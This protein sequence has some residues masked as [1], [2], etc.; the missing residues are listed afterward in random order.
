M[1]V[2]ASLLA[3][4]FL[5]CA[6]AQAETTTYW[7]NGAIG[8]TFNT[9][10]NWLVSDGSGGYVTA[11]IYPPL[12][13]DTIIKRA[14][15]N[16][17]T[18]PLPAW[19]T[20]ASST[21]L[22]T[23]FTIGEWANESA[24]NTAW[25]V[26]FKNAN[27]TFNTLTQN[28]TSETRLRRQAS[29]SSLDF[30]AGTVNVSLGKVS[31]GF[32][33]ADQFAGTVTITNSIN[34][35]GGEFASS[36]NTFN[37]SAATVNLNGG[38]MTINQ[39][40]G[41]GTA[42]YLVATPTVATL[43][44]VNIQAANVLAFGVSGRYIQTASIDTLNATN[45]NATNYAVIDAYATNG[46]TINEIN[47][48]D[49]RFYFNAGNGVTI[50]ENFTVLGVGNT[51][52]SSRGGTTTVKK[53]LDIAG[54]SQ[55][56]IILNGNADATHDSYLSVGGITGGGGTS[57]RRISTQYSTNPSSVDLGNAYITITGV[58]GT[59]GN[60]SVFTGRLHDM[61][62]SHT[63]DQMMDV[64]KIYVTMNSTDPTAKQ[65]IAG[66]TYYRGDTTIIN[67]NLYI[68][69]DKTGNTT[70]GI[71]KVI[72][73]GGG[74]GA[75]G[76]GDA[77]GN[78]AA[79]GTVYATDL[80]WSGGSILVDI[81]GAT[82][83]KLIFSGTVGMSGAAESYAIN[84]NIINFSEGQTYE[85]IQWTDAGSAADFDESK[86]AAEFEQAGYSAL[87]EKTATGLNV[88]LSAIPEPAQF[89]ALFGLAALLIA[90]RRKSRKN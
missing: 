24:S 25:D 69:A 88:T 12:T 1:R 8:G 45:P 43:G 22:Q 29:A 6:A 33:G 79:V 54:T 90:I 66:Q 14:D 71:A 37:A 78:V 57:S 67:G 15:Q 48:T 7:W 40:F 23:T 38:N 26:Y 47:A 42:G 65:Y 82:A 70:W 77:A 63:I 89:A 60:T 13:A 21:P 55:C 10:S 35:T 3:A 74:F 20:N 83:D 85:I 87:F 2:K 75:C 44:T 31:L 4:A 59:T 62:Q 34:V 18:V 30:T 39:S 56:S 73:Q 36:A 16:S 86:L 9:A 17:S 50:N 64:G 58:D 84:F 49:T 72:L 68:K 27:I 11:S 81:D 19:T 52:F 28:S 41:A 32:N 80:D 51:Y 46:L 76:A 53:Y 61:A 5:T